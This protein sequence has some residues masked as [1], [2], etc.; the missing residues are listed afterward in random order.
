MKEVPIQ[1]FSIPEVKNGQIITRTYSGR[2]PE[3]VRA[4]AHDYLSSRGVSQLREQ[5]EYT[6]RQA[7][8]DPS[9]QQSIYNDHVTYN[10]RTQ[11]AIQAEL[12]K[13]MEDIKTKTNPTEIAALAEQQTRLESQLA[14]NSLSLKSADEYFNRDSSEI[15]NDIA[16]IVTNDVIDG[17][18]AT[19]GGYA[20]STKVEPDRTFLELAKMQQRADE[21]KINTQLEV[22]KMQQDAELAGA[23]LEFEKTKA[24]EVTAKN[25]MSDGTPAPNYF[26]TSDPTHIDFVSTV[27]SLN[28]TTQKLYA[29]QANIFRDGITHGDNPMSG[30]NFTLEMLIDPKSVDKFSQNPYYGESPYFKA[31]LK[32]KDELYTTDRALAEY[33]GKRPTNNY[34]WDRLKEAG[35]KIRARVEQ[36]MTSPK[37][38][39]E[40]QFANYLQDVNA[41]LLSLQEFM[42]E[43]NASGSP[44][45]YIKNK[46]NIKIYSNAVYDFDLPEN[47]SKGEK[48][49]LAQMEELFRPTF[50]NY[51]DV[52]AAVYN[53][54]STNVSQDTWDKSFTDPAR[55]RNI[56]YGQIRK[57][58]SG[59][60][61]TLKVFMKDSAFA[62]VEKD[63]TEDPLK[64]G[65]FASDDKYMMVK[66][67]GYY[68]QVKASD[69]KAKGYFEIKDPRF[70]KLNWSNQLG[71][72]VGAKPQ[73]RWDVTADGQ[74]VSFETRRSTVNNHVQASVNGGPWIEYPTS[75]VTAVITQLRQR[76]STATLQEITSQ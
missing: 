59:P 25:L 29:L 22:A 39:D 73:K 13:V 30:E 43:A 75:D 12:D 61:G 15:I 7:G 74:S 69:I 46:Q 62:K 76:I 57:I 54:K 50:E 49:R 44:E 28:A 66:N 9:F 48:A 23:K 20:I 35:S 1:K 40:A 53:S 68:Q 64:S 31:F 27:D 38:R 19:Y 60:D 34:E 4:A 2:D 56:P 45:E 17:T 63:G 67:G 70:N 8:T 41:N 11:K 37:D 33:M 26:S 51:I 72:T 3:A 36:I 65:I 24:G 5:A 21:F 14:Q 47:A 6:F 42:T 71:Y 10:Q 18:K 32:A 16:S 58:E 55:V 52:P